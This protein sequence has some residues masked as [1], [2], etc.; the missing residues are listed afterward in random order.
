[1][2][3]VS[4]LSSRNTQLE[5]DVIEVPKLKENCLKL[6]QQ[7]EISLLLLGEKEEELEA[8]VMDMK[9]IKH[10]YTAHIAELIEKISTSGDKD[11]AQVDAAIDP[12]PMA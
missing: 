8:M 1:L 11:L 2:E 6:Q 3:E 4:F 10:M 5:E 12:K 9:E 7:L